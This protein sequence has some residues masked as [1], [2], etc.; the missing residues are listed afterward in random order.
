MNAR[1]EV[2]AA[3][4]A[5][6]WERTIPVWSGQGSFYLTRG[7]MRITVTFTTAGALHGA[8]ALEQVD[9]S[10][11]DARERL[12]QGIRREGGVDRRRAWGLSPKQARKRET[13]VDHLREPA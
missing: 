9:A 2:F 7:R 11:L 4:D 12:R 13:L 3:A 8:T 6:G 10:Q 5:N 1:E